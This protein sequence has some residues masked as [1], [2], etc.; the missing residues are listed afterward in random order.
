MAHNYDRQWRQVDEAIV[1][2]LIGGAALG[3]S[4]FGTWGAI[5]GGIF[6]AVCGSMV[7]A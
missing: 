3:S 5:I 1:A 7:R 2:G 4:G 6:G